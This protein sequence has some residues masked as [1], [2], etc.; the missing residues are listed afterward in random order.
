LLLNVT[1]ISLI[2]LK[3]KKLRLFLDWFLA[4]RS[5]KVMTSQLFNQRS[6]LHK[7]LDFVFP[8]ETED[9]N[10]VLGN[11]EMVTSVFVFY[12]LDNIWNYPSAPLLTRSIVV[13]KG[14]LQI[15]KHLVC[16]TGNGSGSTKVPNTIGSG[17]QNF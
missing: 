2:S 9:V 7:I 1:G 10:K 3:T 11:S 6:H 12:W 13:L 14:Y 15:T 17:L 16:H 8:N 5:Q 4:Q